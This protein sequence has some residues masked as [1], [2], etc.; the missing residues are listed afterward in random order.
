MDTSIT[1]VAAT[2][3]VAAANSFLTVVTRHLVR[4]RRDID[5]DDPHAQQERRVAPRIE[6]PSS[7]SHDGSDS[8]FSCIICLED[9]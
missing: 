1:A 7:T 4:H 8:R 2:A 3:A 6:P 5:D 9:V